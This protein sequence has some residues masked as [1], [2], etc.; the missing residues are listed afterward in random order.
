MDNSEIYSCRQS[1]GRYAVSIRNRQEIVSAL[2]TF[3]KDKNIRSG[4]ISGI[5]AV[6]KAV[7]RFFNPQTKQYVDRTFTGQMEIAGLAGNI[8]T[9][10]GEIYL[11]L[12]ITL[13]CE[14]YSAKAGLQLARKYG[15]SMPI[16]EEVNSILFEGKPASDAVRDLMCREKRVEHAEIKW[17]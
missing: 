13:G 8:S 11:H 12:H 6:D 3:C 9:L 2:A 1:A 5:G 4:E 15:V 7:L 14:D 16:V 17:E 10:D